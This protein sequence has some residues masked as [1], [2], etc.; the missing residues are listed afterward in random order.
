MSIND[1]AMCCC[2]KL[3]MIFKYVNRML[4]NNYREISIM[5]KLVEIYDALIYRTD[6]FY[7]V[8]MVSARLVHKGQLHSTKIIVATT[9]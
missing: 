9:V 4:C 1:E 3:V 7:G 8:S 6:H 5:G 2:T